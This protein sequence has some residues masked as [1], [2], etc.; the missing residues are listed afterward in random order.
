VLAGFLLLVSGLV[1]GCIFSPDRGDGDKPP[2]P[3]LKYPVLSTPAAVL[4]ALRIAYE[5][6]DSS[7]YLKLFDDKYLGATYD[8]S[9][10]EEGN[11]AGTFTRVEEEKH[12]KSLAE[13]ANITSVDLFL[14]GEPW[15][16]TTVIDVDSGE[17]WG[18]ITIYNPQIGVTEAGKDA[19][20]IVAN[21]TFQFRFRP[22]SVPP[23]S[24]DTGKL[25][26]IVRW[27]EDP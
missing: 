3:P 17:E 26:H 18:L 1:A 10:V 5:N 12:I 22:R 23:E 9:E 7:G 14:P 21:E 13:N 4:T 2:P 27:N 11:Q 8:T 25:W 16:V 6:R 15:T 20:R 24:S 19:V